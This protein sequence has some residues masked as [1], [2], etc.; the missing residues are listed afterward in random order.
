MWSPMKGDKKNVELLKRLLDLMEKYPD[1]SPDRVIILS[2]STEALSGIFTPS[3]IELVKAIKYEK[4]RSV[5]ELAKAVKRPVESV[6]RD[7]KIL[8]NYGIL[9]FVQSGKQKIPEIGKDVLMM[10]LA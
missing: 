3:R 2:M 5:G 8:S 9:E 6:S 1:V 7:L 10:P 4:P